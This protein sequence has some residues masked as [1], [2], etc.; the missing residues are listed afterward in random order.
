MP[1]RPYLAATIHKVPLVSFMG[2]TTRMPAAL[3]LRV[4]SIVRRAKINDLLKEPVGVTHIQM[5]P[6][7]VQ[8]PSGEFR[9]LS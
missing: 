1:D 5:L 2:W 9:R 6:L 8:L 7:H 4:M 3:R